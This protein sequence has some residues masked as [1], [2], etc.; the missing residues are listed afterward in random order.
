LNIGCDGIPSV[1]EMFARASSQLAGR[2]FLL[3]GN[4]K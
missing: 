4:R 3:T 2:S 1:P